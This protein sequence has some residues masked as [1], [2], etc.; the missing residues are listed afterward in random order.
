MKVSP[1]ADVRAPVDRPTSGLG[2]G[3]ALPLAGIVVA[4]VSIAA[5]ADPDTIED[6][7]VVCPFRLM[8][9]LPC[10]GCGLTRSWVYLLHGR[11]LDSVSANPFGVVVFGLAVAFVV[12]ILVAILRR[13]PVPDAGPLIR[14][15]PA[16]ALGVVWVAY[17]A[18]R[19]L[20]VLAAR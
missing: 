13:R 8:T 5:V 12:S 18:A 2:A 17:G 3:A 9:G 11:W 15:K 14:S 20:V 6:G 1:S 7:P 10:P 19:L 16:I 4:A